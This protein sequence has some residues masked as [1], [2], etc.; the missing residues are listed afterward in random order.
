[1]YEQFRA[2]RHIIDPFVIPQMATTES[3]TLIAKALALMEGAD[4]TYLFIF[5]EGQYRGTV[6]IMAI[7]RALLEHGCRH[8]D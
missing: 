6:S 5:D 4:T 3:N 1:M 7:G 8:G 2:E